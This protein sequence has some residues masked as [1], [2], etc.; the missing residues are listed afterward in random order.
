MKKSSNKQV[1]SFD[2]WKAQIE[3]WIKAE[4]KSLPELDFK[5]LYKRNLSASD[6]ISDIVQGY[7]V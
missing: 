2:A 3:T 6:V 7:L 4:G 1:C 5:K